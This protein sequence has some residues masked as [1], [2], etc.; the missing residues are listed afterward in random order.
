MLFIVETM[1]GNKDLKWAVWRRDG[2]AQSV[3]KKI[4]SVVSC[5]G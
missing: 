4:N 1:S 3:R 5:G 2:Y